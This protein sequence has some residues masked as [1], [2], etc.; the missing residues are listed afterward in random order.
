MPSP[1]GTERMKPLRDRAREGRANPKGIPYLYGASSKE[2]A[3][4]EV[5]PWLGSLVSLAQFKMLRCVKLVNCKT[6]KKRRPYLSKSIPKEDWDN[7]V[8]QDIDLAFAR[9]FTV[10]EDTASYVPTQIIAELFKVNG[11]DGLVYRSAFGGGYN[12]VLFDLDCAD[13]INC[14]LYEVKDIHFNISQASNT[15]FVSKYNK[16]GGV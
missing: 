4:A 8:W 1:F 15:Y 11:L 7:A 12:M 5:R 6:T 3:I 9:P 10:G 2:T 14:S 16:N 13:I